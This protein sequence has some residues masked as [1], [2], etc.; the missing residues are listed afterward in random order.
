MTKTTYTKL[1]DGSWGVRAPAGTKAGDPITVTKR[2]G[3]TK[4][5]RVERVLWEGD[6]IALCA[7]APSAPSAKSGGY[8]AQRVS[9]AGGASDRCRECRGPIRHAPEHRAMGGLCGS[10]AFD[11]YD[12]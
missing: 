8:S 6:G 11:E 9:R 7:I 2:D 12:C 1:R 4:P 3:T 5:E 10:C